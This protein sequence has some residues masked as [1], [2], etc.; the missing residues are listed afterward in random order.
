M[1][2]LV[3]RSVECRWPRSPAPCKARTC[4]YLGAGC[5]HPAAGTQAE[6]AQLGPWAWLDGAL[7]A[8]L[9][10]SRSVCSASSSQ[11]RPASLRAADQPRDSPRDHRAPELGRSERVV[12]STHS[13]RLRHGAAVAFLQSQLPVLMPPLALAGWAIGY[14]PSLF[15]NF[16]KACRVLTSRGLQHRW[17]RCGP[18]CAWS[19]LLPRHAQE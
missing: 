5:H 12:L 10:C 7:P 17:G 15:F 3:A 18:A 16:A 6:G 8:G 19:Q 14:G 4:G 11:N 9:A 2:C 1:T 13:G